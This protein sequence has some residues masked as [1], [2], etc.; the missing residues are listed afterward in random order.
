MNSTASAAAAPVVRLADYRREPPSS[1]SSASACPL[2]PSP[3]EPIEGTREV[4]SLVVEL[5][6]YARTYPEALR[7]IRNTLAMCRTEFGP[8]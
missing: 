3:G 4:A 2:L 8:V 6:D 7:W 1:P 5:S